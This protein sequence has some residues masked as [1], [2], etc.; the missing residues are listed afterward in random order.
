MKDGKERRRI[1]HEMREAFH[2][3]LKRHWAHSR[4]LKPYVESDFKFPTDPHSGIYIAWSH[5]LVGRFD[6]IPLV[7]VGEYL[8]LICKLHVQIEWKDEPGSILSSH[9]GDID[10]RIK[11]LFDALSLPQKEQLPDNSTPHPDQIPFLCLL[12]DDKLISEL[13]VMYLRQSRRLDL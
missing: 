11:P 10:N 5:H 3:Q 13:T 12:E 6:F 4:I 2:T 1:Q 8:K 7:A 9:S